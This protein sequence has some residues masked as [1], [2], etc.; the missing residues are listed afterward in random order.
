[1]SQSLKQNWEDWEGEVVET[2]RFR[3]ADDFEVFAEA[4][5]DV[6]RII[7][8]PPAIAEPP[9]AKRGTI[10]DVE[11]A[12][13]C[14]ACGGYGSRQN[15]FECSVCRGVGFVTVQENFEYYRAKG[16][17]EINKARTI[18]ESQFEGPEHPHL[19]WVQSPEAQRPSF[20]TVFMRTAQLMAERGTCPR[21]KVGA[22]ITV[23]NRIIAT[24][25]NGAPAGLPHCTEVGCLIVQG[26]CKR[27]THAEA[28]ALIQC[29]KFGHSTDGGTLYITHRPCIACIG[30]A[31]TAGIKRF[32][33]AAPYDTD[34][35][36]VEVRGMIKAG[37]GTYAIYDPKKI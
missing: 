5:S 35:L 15:Q 37:G 31:I 18:P 25:Y 9:K 3:S 26:S 27:T 10:V 20:D 17:A 22:V 28:N 23:D 1:M 7:R 19:D 13:K 14:P 30:L 8:T 36:D 32:V 6:I 33:W 4:Y 12:L 2:I 11:P 24:G 34:G 21:L 29:A 16:E